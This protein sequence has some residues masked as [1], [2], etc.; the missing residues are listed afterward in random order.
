[1]LSMV[2]FWVKFIE[3]YFIDDNILFFDEIIVEYVG[4][5]LERMYLKSDD[6]CKLGFLL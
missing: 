3:G 1:M 5:F 6:W 2:G 4:W